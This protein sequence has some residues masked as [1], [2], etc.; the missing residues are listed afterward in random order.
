MSQPNK[1]CPICGYVEYEEIDIC[2]EC[3][4]RFGEDLLKHIELNRPFQKGARIKA[5]LIALCAAGFIYAVLMTGLPLLGVYPG[6]VLV[7]LICA[8]TVSLGEYIAIRTIAPALENKKIRKVLKRNK[9]TINQPPEG[10]AASTHSAPLSTLEQLNRAIREAEETVTE[11]PSI[12]H[13]EVERFVSFGAITED[14]ASLQHAAIQETEARRAADLESLEDMYRMRARL[15]ASEHA[16]TEKPAKRQA[17]SSRS[18]PLILAS[19]LCVLFLL[20]TIGVG[21]F[22]WIQY[23]SLAD[24]YQTLHKDTEAY[25]ESLLRTRIELSEAEES[26]NNLSSALSK[27]S[28]QRYAAGFFDA[29]RDALKLVSWQLAYAGADDSLT[30]EQWEEAYSATSSSGKLT[31]TLDSNPVWLV[32]ENLTCHTPECVEMNGKES[33]CVLVPACMVPDGF[34]RCDLCNP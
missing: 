32:L 13:E 15:E 7:G 23:K 18:A 22:G 17:R 16:R 2:G 8:G 1:K 21:L 24:E 26:K 4:Y 11:A 3:G 10:V 34:S 27:N 14:Q 9:N 25:Q 5:T 30:I 6:F 19:C 20:T 28:K 33:F 12:T 29:C 31:L